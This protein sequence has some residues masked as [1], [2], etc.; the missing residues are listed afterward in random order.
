MSRDTENFTRMQR[1]DL[2]FNYGDTEVNDLHPWQA[3]FGLASREI[4]YDDAWELWCAAA[5]GKEDVVKRLIEKDPR[6]KDIAF[7]YHCPLDLAV[8]G[9]HTECVKILL[10]AGT[11]LT[12]KWG[13]Y[14][15]KR[16]I[17]IADEMGHDEIRDLMRKRIENELNFDPEIQLMIQ[18][19]CDQDLKRMQQLI[20]EDPNRVN[21]ADEDGNTALHWAVVSR[22][23]PMIDL[24]VE[25]GADPSRRN[26]AHAMPH[27]VKMWD[28]DRKMYRGLD[29]PKDATAARRRPLELGA[30]VD[31]HTAIDQRDFDLVKKMLEGDPKLVHHMPGHLE[32]PLNRAVGSLEMIQLLLDH[33]ADP[34][35]CEHTAPFGKA[36]YTAVASNRYDS[37]KLLLE[38]GAEPMCYSDS[39]GDCL[40]A[41][42]LWVK[43]LDD[44]KRMIDLLNEYSGKEY[45]VIPQRNEK[46]EHAIA[47]AQVREALSRD[48]VSE[49]QKGHLLDTILLYRDADLLTEYIERFKGEA[50]TRIAEVDL[51]GFEGRLLEQ[52]TELGAKVKP[53]STEPIWIG[54]SVLH[55]SKDVSL[56]AEFVEA[57]G[58]INSNNLETQRTALSNA[59]QRGDVAMVRE[60][61]KHGADP[62]LPEKFKPNRP[63]ALAFEE[64]HEEVV[65]LL[66]ESGATPLASF[67]KGGSN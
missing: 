31:F 67:E 14:G 2:S 61:L 1:P 35:M 56:V 55:W 19:L 6:L 24:L 21:I 57:G 53:V 43:D 65:A 15:W 36:L 5:D 23:I 49:W 51:R 12:E 11:E 8:Y 59:A 45:I 29:T 13:W 9:G 22:Q 28:H 44:R 60:L 46:P 39:S 62:N 7:R 3:P 37:A 42:N 18:A 32:S 27:Q 26:G 30:E 47:A 41:A 40:F 58:A 64:G 34:T 16:M 66:L 20:D 17:G 10:G 4:D 25:R 33:G 54:A 38:N 48:S 50:R 63:L 52:L